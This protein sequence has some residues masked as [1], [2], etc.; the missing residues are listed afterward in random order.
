[1]DWLIAFPIML[2]GGCLIGIIS[3]LCNLPQ[4]TQCSKILAF[5]SLLLAS[6][7]VGAQVSSSVAGSDLCV[8]ANNNTIALINDMFDN[9]TTSAA[10]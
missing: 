4:I 6:I 1:M 3:A 9:T 7:M 10:T 5:M 8:D 2:G